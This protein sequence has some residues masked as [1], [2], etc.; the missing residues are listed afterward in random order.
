M[1]SFNNR[2]HP[3]FSG[4]NNN[5]QAGRLGG[6]AMQVTGT[7]ATITYAH[8]ASVGAYVVVSAALKWSAQFI[9]ADK[10]MFAVRGGGADHFYL[11]VASTSP[12]PQ[13]IELVRAGTVLATSTVAID[14]TAWNHYQIETTLA[15]TATGSVK[16]SVNGA[17]VINVTNVVTAANASGFDG[18]QWTTWGNTLLVDDFLLVD[19]T[20][21]AP[22]NGPLGD[23]SIETIRPDGNGAS[24]AWVGSD[25]NSVDNYLLVD[26]IGS[27]VDYVGTSTVGARDLYALGPLVSAAAGNVLA[28]Q[29]ELY[30]A[31]SDSGAAPGP[32]N[33]L[34]RSAAGTVRTD[35]AAGVAQLAT[36]YQWFTGPVQ[37]LDPDGNP[38]SVSA[39]AGLQAGVEVGT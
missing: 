15:T 12:G 19:N 6:N 37:T 32:L 9:A 18:A 21:P 30:A 31:K 10:R 28:V 25:G 29:V 17:E 1:A 35:L 16:V 36:S 3:A 39:V 20:G 38:W 7:T 5:S 33:A 23:C 14:V 24:S 2:V 22:Y 13:L 34:T 27:S 11:R 4:Y 26:D 8:G